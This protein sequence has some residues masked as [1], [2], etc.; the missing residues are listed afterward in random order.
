MRWNVV[1]EISELEV[2]VYHF[3][4]EEPSCHFTVHLRCLVF[5][6]GVIVLGRPFRSTH[7]LEYEDSEHIHHK[8]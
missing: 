3:E 8:V 5:N 4:V 7:L 1:P 6:L 2:L